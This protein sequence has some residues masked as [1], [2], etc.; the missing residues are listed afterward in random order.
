LSCPGERP[1]VFKPPA[2]GGRPAA[3]HP[4]HLLPLA[5]FRARLAGLCRAF[6]IAIYLH[7]F[8]Y[9]RAGSSSAATANHAAR[10]ALWLTWLMPLDVA[11]Q[12]LRMCQ[13]KQQIKEAR[14]IV[15]LIIDFAHTVSLEVIAEGVETAAHLSHLRDLGRDFAQGYFFSRPFDPNAAEGASRSWGRKW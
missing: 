12:Q 8:L 3:R 10:H 5:R 11:Y 1:S 2:N 13:L 14:A 6:T 9:V 7:I 4:G 15:H